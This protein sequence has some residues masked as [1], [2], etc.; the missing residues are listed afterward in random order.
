MLQA[1]G[2]AAGQAEWVD[3]SLCCRNGNLP[4][5]SQQC[6]YFPQKPDL[7]GIGIQVSRAQELPALPPVGYS[8]PCGCVDAVLTLLPV[9]L[10]NCSAC[11]MGCSG[12]GMLIWSSVPSWFCTVPIGEVPSPYPPS[13][14]SPGPAQPAE[15]HHPPHSCH[16]Q[17]ISKCSF[18]SS[19]TTRS[20]SHRPRAP[21][22]PELQQG[23][24]HLSFIP[25]GSSPG[26]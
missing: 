18:Q 12:R 7:A 6:Q 16:S 20:C 26:Q 17:H 1:A 22:N 3:D 8:V 9:Q 25:A 4:H 10:L 19:H 14:H 2:A 24:S 13:V 15:E 11:A 23:V 21:T 5:T